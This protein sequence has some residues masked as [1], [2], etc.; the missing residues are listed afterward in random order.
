MSNAVGADSFCSQGRHLDLNLAD[1]PLDEGVNA[2]TG[3]A[4]QAL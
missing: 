1:I 4:C 3:G 2:E